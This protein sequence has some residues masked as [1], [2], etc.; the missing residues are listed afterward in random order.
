MK[1][2][3]AIMSYGKNEDNYYFLITRKEKHMILM[4]I[5]SIFFKILHIVTPIDNQI[6]RRFL[7]NNPFTEH[8]EHL[9]KT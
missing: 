8:S 5:E 9:L 1:L 7:Q 2:I 4:W 3:N 6:V